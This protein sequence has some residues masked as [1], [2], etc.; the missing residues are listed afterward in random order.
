[1]KRL[2]LMLVLVACGGGQNEVEEPTQLPPAN[3]EAVRHLVAGARLV[4][5][6]PQAHR[7]AIRRFRQAIE[8]DPNLWEAHYNL[9]VVLRL[10]GQ[11]EE[12]ATSFE[13]AIQIQPAA[14][15]P[16]RAAAEV[17]YARED[18]SEASDRL[19]MLVRQHPDDL[20]ART[21]LAVL[22]RER[23]R[24]NDSLEQARE[25]L[26]RD[27][28]QTRALLEIGRVY[29]A[30][31]DFEVARLVLQKALALAPEDDVRLRA[32]IL[33]ERG[34]LELARGDTQAAFEAF[35]GAIG[36]DASY[37]PA[38]MN[39][40]SVLLHAGDYEGAAAQY[41][42]VLR[43]DED[44]LAARVA[45][46]VALRGKGEHR[47]ARRQYE[48]VLEADAEQPDALL[49]LAI[50]RA[51]FVDERTQSRETFQRF[52]DVAPRRHPGRER[53]EEFL[54]LIPAPGAQNGGGP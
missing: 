1:M 33:D 48:Q 54:R 27:P 46:G 25:V 10:E 19:Q 22:F 7:R 35:E 14:V 39:M 41:Q 6:G 52:L 53:A 9:G 12:A 43:I 51:E 4:A 30:R 38:R 50:L 23:E 26:V 37:K 11:L 36:V 28:S 13:A 42:A 29:R 40:G 24:W 18:L 32:E 44:D 5:R 3:P 17:A 15:E 21:A 47:Q 31:E 34:R 45:Y 49:N 20:A 2:L 8:L 16:L